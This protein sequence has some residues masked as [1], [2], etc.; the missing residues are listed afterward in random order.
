VDKTGAVMTRQAMLAFASTTIV[1]GTFLSSAS[2]AAALER[3]VTNHVAGNCTPAYGPSEVAVRKRPLSVQNEGRVDAFVTCSVSS[4]GK[5]IRV[6]ILL[7][8]FD[9]ARHDVSCTGV[10][11]FV[12]WPSTIYMPTA[13]YVTGTSRYGV[14]WDPASLGRT[15]FPS[16][17]FSISCKIPPGAGISDLTVVFEEDV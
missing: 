13:F 4:Q 14:Y 6:E 16:D 9:G 10:S 11:G 17:L 7:Y 2:T 12:S 5:P 1:L 3:T 8:S 15:S